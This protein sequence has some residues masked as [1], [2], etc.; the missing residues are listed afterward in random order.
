MGDRE[1]SGAREERR[2]RGG[3]RLGPG[4]AKAYRAGAARANYLGLGHI[5]IQFGATEA[6]KRMRSP[7]EAALALVKQMPARFGGAGDRGSRKASKRS[8]S[9][10]LAMYCGCM[11]KSWSSA[12]GRF[13]PSSAERRSTMRSARPVVRSSVCDS[14]SETSE[15]RAGL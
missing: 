2:G 15:C 12:Q 7:Y 1:W 5:D 3:D 4:Q 13:A 8:T 10:G 6:C 14:Y 9:G 11:L